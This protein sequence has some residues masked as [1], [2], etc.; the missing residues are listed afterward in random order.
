M[1]LLAS[2]STFDCLGLDAA[3]CQAR[4][5][6]ALRLRS[7]LFLLQAPSKQ[8]LAK[9]RL[10]LMSKE[11]VEKDR[12]RMEG[13]FHFGVFIVPLQAASFVRPVRHSLWQERFVASQVLQIPAI[14]VAA[15]FKSSPPCPCRSFFVSG[16]LRCLGSRFCIFD[17]EGPDQGP[18]LVA[19]SRCTATYCA[20]VREGP[21]LHQ[22]EEQGENRP[23]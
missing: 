1:A 6:S 21:G 11:K 2:A 8:T 5:A 9:R 20:A 13:A 7:P 16:P 22:A 14:F 12:L 19:R 23:Q 4:P 3:A 17:F 18:V 10:Q 15:L